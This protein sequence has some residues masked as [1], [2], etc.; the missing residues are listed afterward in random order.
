M[1]V[2]PRHAPCHHTRRRGHMIQLTGMGIGLT[3]GEH[4]L[5]RWR[6]RDC[7]QFAGRAADGPHV[8]LP[9]SPHPPRR[10]ARSHAQ[11][12]GDGNH[13]GNNPLGG[14]GASCRYNTRDNVT[15]MTQLSHNAG[16]KDLI[17]I[18]VN[19]QK[20]CE[21]GGRRYDVPEAMK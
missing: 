13:D 7:G 16:G 2:R 9:S 15:Q 19:A 14:G 11:E 6:V 18:A 8:L 21:E 1:L 4:L 17:C 5:P 3:H 12:N 20:H 10:E